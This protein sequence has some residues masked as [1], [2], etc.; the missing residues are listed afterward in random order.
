MKLISAYVV[1]GASTLLVLSACSAV[2]PS[3]IID[4]PASA[5][6][7]VV[8]L[9]NPSNGTIFQSDNF[10]PFFEDRRARAVGD[11]LTILVSEK[12]SVDKT[13]AASGANSGSFNSRIG[14]LFALPAT[15]VGLLSL[16]GNSSVNSSNK[17]AGSA[18]YNF[19]T[20][21]GVT[22]VEVL[23]NGN[24]L[25]SGEKQIGLD[26]GSEF[27]RFSGV[28]P[29]SSIGAGNTVS[30][31]QVADARIEYRTNTQIDKSQMSS[32]INRLFYSM[33]PL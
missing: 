4:A 30:S 8:A 13:N 12:S 18:S 27:V 17:S 16:N 10:K 28:V 14:Q 5:R 2:A 23:A 1:A 33:L 7:K 15:S 29:V 22:V 9:N 19:S 26:R 3:S 25:V 11:V 21:M 24:L 31:T 6:P 32:M 20:T